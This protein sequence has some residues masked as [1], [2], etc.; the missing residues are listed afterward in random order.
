MR[1]DGASQSISG[2]DGLLA[3]RTT[4]LVSIQKLLDSFEV[5]G[6]LGRHVVLVCE[7]TRIGLRAMETMLRQ[8]VGHDERAFKTGDTMPLEYRAPETLL[9]AGWSY[10][11]DIWSVG[12]TVCLVAI[13]LM[14][15]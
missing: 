3:S 10:P 9:D 1:H 7:V 4:E 15:S 14:S 8:G 13:I 11:V 6:P 2:S 12:L 5:S